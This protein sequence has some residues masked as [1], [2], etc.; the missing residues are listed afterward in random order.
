MCFIE[1]VER[2][3]HPIAEPDLLLAPA[4]GG[5]RKVE[6]QAPGRGLR[7][8]RA[9]DAGDQEVVEFGE[10]GSV[11]GWSVIWLLGLAETSVRSNRKTHPSQV[12][13]PSLDASSSALV[14]VGPGRGFAWSFV[15]LHPS[16]TPDALVTSWPLVKTRSSKMVRL[17]PSTRRCTNVPRFGGTAT[18]AEASVGAAS[19][20]R[21]TVAQ[22]ASKM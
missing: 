16:F 13:C 8:L 15:P 6:Q 10:E 9:C 7:L 21:N 12:K 11:Q 18:A 22:S 4:D 3:Q 20:V 5:E 19:A 14:Q 17:A 2:P 1:G